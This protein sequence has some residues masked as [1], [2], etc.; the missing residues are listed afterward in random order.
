VTIEESEKRSLIGR[1]WAGL[2]LAGKRVFVGLRV[3]PNK[4]FYY[5]L[6]VYRYYWSLSF[7]RVDLHFQYEYF[8]AS[9]YRVNLRY[10]RKMGNDFS[11]IYGETPLTTLEYII[12]RAD[13]S[14]AENVFDVGCGWGRTT[15]F[16]NSLLGVRC[17]GVD[18]IDEY[19]VRAERIRHRLGTDEVVF[20]C[21]DVRD[22][23]YSDADAL[24]IFGTCLPEDV[25]KEMIAVFRR[26]LQPGT[27]VITVTY[28]L[29]HYC[30]DSF[31]T[32]VDTFEVIF[33]WGKSIVHVQIVHGTDAIDGDSAAEERVLPAGSVEDQNDH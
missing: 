10:I 22:V 16:L 27:K 4:V 3:A 31:F 29:T 5:L 7:L 17:I 2:L 18:I 25:I 32:L 8:F 30:D 6:V 12:S 9:P 14:D 19:I 1:L 28:P 26:D 24:Y 21:S 15:F 11:Y 23:N 20:L 33:L 13:L